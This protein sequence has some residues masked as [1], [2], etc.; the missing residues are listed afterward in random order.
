MNGNSGDYYTPKKNN[1]SFACFRLLSCGRHKPALHCDRKKHLKISYYV[2]YIMQFCWDD[3]SQTWRIIRHILCSCHF[4]HLQTIRQSVAALALDVQNFRP[5]KMSVP[6]FSALGSQRWLA[7][8]SAESSSRSTS[9]RPD[10]GPIFSEIHKTP[11][12][13]WGQELAHVFDLVKGLARNIRLRFLVLVI[14][15][16]CG[17]GTVNS[18]MTTQ[19]C[20]QE[21]WT[22]MLQA[23]HERMQVLV[24]PVEKICSLKDLHLRR[25]GTMYFW[26][27]S[28][29]Q[30]YSEKTQEWSYDSNTENCQWPWF[31]ETHV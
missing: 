26:S 27:W 22:Q 24:P 13:N 23:S 11:L 7:L 30:D 9:S 28:K 18:Q 25:G 5:E 14:F 17:T 4:R 31:E 15:C 3:G 21:T 8:A 19:A 29:L 6:V 2:S 1:Q 20:D 16:C 10:E 12:R